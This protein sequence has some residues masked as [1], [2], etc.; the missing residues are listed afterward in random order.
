MFVME[1]ARILGLTPQEIVT[2]ARSTFAAT[3]AGGTSAGGRGSTKNHQRALEIA[4][5]AMGRV[6]WEHYSNIKYKEMKGARK[7]AGFIVTKK[8]NRVCKE[9]LGGSLRETLQTPLHYFKDVDTR[10]NIDTELVWFF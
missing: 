1:L 5:G 8:K 2:L 9:L 4:E 10:W 3:S 6:A 7:P